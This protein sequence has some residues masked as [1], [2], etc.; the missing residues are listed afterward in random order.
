MDNKR[1]LYKKNSKLVSILK[2]HISQN[3]KEY[4]IATIVFIIGLMV[5]VMLVNSSNQENKRNI[6]RLYRRVY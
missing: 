3:I 4:I 1:K 6:I 5:G 2:N